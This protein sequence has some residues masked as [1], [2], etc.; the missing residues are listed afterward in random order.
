MGFRYG[1]IVEDFNTGYELHCEGWE[2]VFCHPQ[3]AAFLGEMP[4]NI[5]DVLNQLKRW[6]VGF[7]EVAFSKH[8]PLVYGIRKA[9]LPMGMCY[10]M[11]SLWGTWCFPIMVYSVVPQMALA[12]QVPLFPKVQLHGATR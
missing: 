1:S 3:R 5:N 4:I 12:H 6:C 2:S 9:S 11:I 10:S 7:L 8:S